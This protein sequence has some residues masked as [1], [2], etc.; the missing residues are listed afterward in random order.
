MWEKASKIA[1]KVLYDL[2][3][4]ADEQAELVEKIGY[5]ARVARWRELGIMPGGCKDEVFNAV[6]KTSTNLNSDP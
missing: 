5:P 1:E 2:R 3:R 6:V 4:P